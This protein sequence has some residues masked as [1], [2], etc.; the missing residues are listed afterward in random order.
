MTPSSSRNRGMA[1]GVHANS[2]SVDDRL[3]EE[4]HIVNAKS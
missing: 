2:D 4:Q 3:L 1:E